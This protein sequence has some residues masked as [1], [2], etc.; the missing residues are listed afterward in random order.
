MGN[1]KEEL[2]LDPKIKDYELVKKIEEARA[3][4]LE[5]IEV[6]LGKGQTI[7]IKLR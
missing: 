5:E 7:K 1:W 4:N 2:G 6:F 3:K